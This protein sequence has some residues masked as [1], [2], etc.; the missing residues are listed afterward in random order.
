MNDRLDTLQA[1]SGVDLG[2]RDKVGPLDAQ[3]PSL[4][5]SFPGHCWGFNPQI[6][7]SPASWP[8]QLR[9]TYSTSAHCLQC[10]GCIA[11]ERIR[12]SNK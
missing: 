4:T 7:R 10:S 3:N 9:N 8:H 5:E 6:L 2:I 1:R 12:L 11:T